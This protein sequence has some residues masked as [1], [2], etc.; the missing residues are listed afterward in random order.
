M[1]MTRIVLLVWLIPSA[2]AAQE[3]PAHYKKGMV[4]EHGTWQVPSVATAMQA[5]LAAA[6]AADTADQT[7]IDVRTIPDGVAPAVAVL[8]QVYERHPP[9]ELDALADEL[10]RLFRDG[11]YFQSSKA[12]G[13]LVDV[14]LDFD[15]EGIRY[16]RARKVFIRLYESFEDPFV[17]RARQALHGVIATGGEDYLLALFNRSTQPPECTRAQWHLDSQGQLVPPENPCPNISLWCDAGGL[18]LE[19]SGKGPDPDVYYPLC[20]LAEILPDGSKV[21]WVH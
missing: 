7:G 20:E 13:I 4:Q 17:P 15:L 2:A 10:A 11:T 9:G 16:A 1:K 5:L 8:R 3:L 12:W 21:I 18:L 14:G 19:K 6:E